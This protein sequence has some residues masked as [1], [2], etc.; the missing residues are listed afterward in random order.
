ME[1]AQ[2][3]TII[4]AKEKVL[5]INLRELWHYRELFFVFAWRDIKVRYKQTVVGILWAILQ[6][7]FLM[8]VFSIFFGT[9]AKVPSNGVP[10][11][12]FVFTGLLFWNY[13]STA[14]TNSSNSLVD[15]ENIIKKIY[16]PRLILP[17]SP[18]ITPIIDF[19]IAFCILIGMMFFY[20]FPLSITG[21]L[22]VP[23]L[24]IIVFLTAAGLGIFLATIN[25]RF[26]DIRYALPFF[27]Q[28]LLFLTPVIYPS[29]LVPERFQWILALN[30]MTGVVETAR[31]VFI[32]QQAIDVSQL[33]VALII[34]V[35]LFIIGTVYFRKNEK[36]FA[37]L[38]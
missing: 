16:F 4:R 7:F 31:T 27:I 10:Y 17:L 20:N 3:T 23:V 15:N 38:A 25:V 13:F 2:T 24:L 11:P 26:R 35:C 6:P 37:D 21:I 14:L 29:T 12:I 34:S 36:E 32:T 1:S 8:V 9:L 22:I 19:F 5:R 28:A 18:T 33:G 30:P